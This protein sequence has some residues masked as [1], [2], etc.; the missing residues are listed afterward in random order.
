L[1]FKDTI[2][3][4]QMAKDRGVMRGVGYR[5]WEDSTI[6]DVCGK[7]KRKTVKGAGVSYDRRRAERLSE[8]WSW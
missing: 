7:K 8:V 2:R 3:F 4:C 1:G 6:G 5:C